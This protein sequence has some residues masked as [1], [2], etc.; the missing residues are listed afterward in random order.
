LNIEASE[1]EFL[2]ALAA[3]SLEDDLANAAKRLAS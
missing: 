1:R 3:A 2:G